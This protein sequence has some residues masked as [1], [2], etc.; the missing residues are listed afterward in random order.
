MHYQDEQSDEEKTKLKH[1]LD[2]DI[3]KNKLEYITSMLNDVDPL[4]SPDSALLL[5]MG[6]DKT[7]NL[8]DDNKLVEEAWG[9]VLYRERENHT[10]HNRLSNLT[11]D[12]VRYGI[13]DMFGLSI[14]EFLK[15]E[16]WVIEKL[17]HISGEIRD[18]EE[19]IL[20]EYEKKKQETGG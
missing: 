5:R 10:L 3:H 20:A 18:E 8:K 7:F 9:P 6:F 2:S 16:E 19:R 15:N 4:S 1:I 11:K 12:Y 17:I 13:K 14:I